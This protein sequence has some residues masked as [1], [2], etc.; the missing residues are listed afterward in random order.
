MFCDS[1]QDFFAEN[2]FFDYVLS[3]FAASEDLLCPAA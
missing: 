2:A 1:A 3:V